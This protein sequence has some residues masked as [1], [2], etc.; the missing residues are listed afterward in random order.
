MATNALLERKG[1]RCCLVTSRGF[2]D[3]LH[4]GNQ[5]RPAI[6]DLEIRVP[7]VLYDTVVEVDEQVAAQ[8]QTV[9]ACKS[10]VMAEGTAVASP[11]QAT[12]Q[13][14]ACSVQA[15]HV[16]GIDFP[17]CH[18][19]PV[20]LFSALSVKRRCRMQNPNSTGRMTM[21]QLP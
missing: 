9:V 17:A 5:S 6:F 7:D 18:A 13:P 21:R 11:V 8:L 14:P 4:I 3:L 12:L 2:R 19:I 15:N 1:E 16:Q 10:H 20:P